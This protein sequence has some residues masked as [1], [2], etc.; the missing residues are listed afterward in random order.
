MKQRLGTIGAFLLAAAL[1]YAIGW[2][3]L[4]AWPMWAMMGFGGAG[5][6]LVGGLVV[7]G[8]LAIAAAGRGDGRRSR[9]DYAPEASNE[10]CPACRAPVEPDYVLCPACHH[11]LGAACPACARHVQAA[12]TRRDLHSRRR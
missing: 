8:L 4:V 10:R 11:A 9:T 5:G 6:L 12:W 2:A 1:I 3:L 7:L